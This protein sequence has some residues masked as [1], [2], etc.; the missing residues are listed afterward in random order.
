MILNC[1]KE[2][3]LPVY[4]K[5]ENIRDWLYVEDHCNAIYTVLQN[6]D[7]GETFNIG[8]NDEIQ[9]IDIVDS[10]CKKMNH[11]LPRRNGK[12][13]ED[14]ITFVD[15]RPGH[16]FRY[17]MDNSKIKNM[18]EWEPKTNFKNGLD[19]TIRWYLD[20]KEWWLSINNNKYQ[21]QRLGL[22]KS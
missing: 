4:G 1:I 9:N 2:K 18:L 16:D 8:G 14:L 20:N 12:K 22:V 19:K 13:Y 7:N 10:I 17:A 11:L 3:K 5:G 6:S 21:Q 15:D